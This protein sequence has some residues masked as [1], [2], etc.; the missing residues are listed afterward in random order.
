MP[1]IGLAG[2]STIGPSCRSASATLGSVPHPVRKLQDGVDQPPLVGTACQQQV[3]PA[4]LAGHERQRLGLG[5]QRHALRLGDLAG[6]GRVGAG[7]HDGHAVGRRRRHAVDHVGPGT[8][9]RDSVAGA[10]DRPLGTA[11][12][13]PAGP[14]GPTR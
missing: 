5:R 10:S 3:A 13:R 8:G 9:R 2:R 12:T 7:H 11:R 6:R 4:D 1:R 14:P